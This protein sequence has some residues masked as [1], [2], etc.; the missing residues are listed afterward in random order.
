MSEAIRSALRRAAKVSPLFETFDLFVQVK[1]GE[2]GRPVASTFD[3]VAS[4]DV[5]IRWKDVEERTT[6]DDVGDGIA[7][8]V[9]QD[10]DLLPDLMRGPDGRFYSVGRSEGQDSLRASQ[11]VRVR[12]WKGDGPT[13]RNAAP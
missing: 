8:I 1:G 3:W 11:R 6:I 7:S 4:G 10:P 2:R 13:I 12:V 5:T 9:A